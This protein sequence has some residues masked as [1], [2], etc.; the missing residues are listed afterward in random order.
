MFTFHVSD[1]GIAMEWY[2]LRFSFHEFVLFKC[3]HK[4]PLMGR[5]LLQNWHTFLEMCPFA[6]GLIVEPFCISKS[7]K[8]NQ[9]KQQNL[10]RNST[11]KNRIRTLLFYSDKIN[12]TCNN[13]CI[14]IPPSKTEYE[15]SCFIRTAHEWNSLDQETVTPASMSPIDAF[16]TRLRSD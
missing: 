16:M 4:N 10:H 12:Q 8:Q 14:K 7:R 11:I 9:P 3:K 15:H 2:T 1:Q 6:I 13:T 5:Q